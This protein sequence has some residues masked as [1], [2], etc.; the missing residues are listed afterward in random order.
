MSYVLKT[1]Y[2]KMVSYVPSHFHHN[3]CLNF[4]L[5]VVLNQ[6]ILKFVNEFVFYTIWKHSGKKLNECNEYE[7]FKITFDVS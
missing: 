5:F 6:L 4:S 1:K 3:E 2:T 7:I